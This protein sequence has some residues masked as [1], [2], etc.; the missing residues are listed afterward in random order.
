MP[1]KTLFGAQQS[2]VGKGLKNFLSS[3]ERQL[4]FQAD[5]QMFFEKL[6]PYAVAFGVEKI[7][8]KRFEKF[9][10]KPPDWYQGYPGSTFNSVVFANSLNSSYSS[11]SSASHPPASTGSGFGGGG[12]S[13][14]GGGGGGGGRW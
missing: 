5:K 13:G 1:R 4:K 3:Q 6:L 14:G 8:A 7:W 11:F 2:T 12:F 10:L 9:D